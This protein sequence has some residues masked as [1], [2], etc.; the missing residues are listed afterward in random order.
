MLKDDIW[1]PNIPA[2][3]VLSVTLKNLLIRDETLSCASLFLCG[4]LTI[5]F[6]W[7]ND[8]TGLCHAVKIQCN[9]FNLILNFYGGKWKKV[10]TFDLHHIYTFSFYTLEILPLFCFSSQMNWVHFKLSVLYFQ[11]TASKKLSYSTFCFSE[12]C[13]RDRWRTP[14]CQLKRY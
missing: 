12:L 6:E 11:T 1:I 10:Q 7:S 8:R 5:R 4:L 2:A 3:F 9:P 14:D 13:F